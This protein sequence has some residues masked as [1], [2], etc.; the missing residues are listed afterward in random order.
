MLSSVSK[1]A[2]RT[3]RSPIRKLVFNQGSL[4]QNA[5][6]DGAEDELAIVNVSGEKAVVR[7][8]LASAFLLDFPENIEAAG[9]CTLKF[10]DDNG[11]IRRLHAP[12]NT[13]RTLQ[14]SGGDQPEEVG[15]AVELLLDAGAERSGAEKI[16]TTLSFMMAA[17]FYGD[18]SKL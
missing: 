8:K 5:V 2:P 15:F 16:A 9:V 4:S 7:N 12:V 11:Q 17:M 1:P 13:V 6:S 18:S 10:V 14:Q 3:W